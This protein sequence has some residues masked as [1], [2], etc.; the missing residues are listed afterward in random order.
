MYRAIHAAMPTSSMFFTPSRT[1]NSGISSMKPIS[2]ICPSVCLPAAF[3]DADLVEERIG[4][5]V[6]EL[7]RDADEE[8]AEHEDRERALLHQLQR[9][10]A[11][12]VA[13]IDAACPS[14][15]AACAAGTKQ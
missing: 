9:V 14:F 5:R 13:T 10:E 15:A 6:V 7:Q 11:E 2:D 8:R 1:K 4:E 12:D 3:D